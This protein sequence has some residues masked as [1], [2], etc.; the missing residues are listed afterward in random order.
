MDAMAKKEIFKAQ[1]DGAWLGSFY[2]ITD[3][4]DRESYSNAPGRIHGPFEYDALSVTS[5]MT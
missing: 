4:I 2:V 3:V 1:L 5:V